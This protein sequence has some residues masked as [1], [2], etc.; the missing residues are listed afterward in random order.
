M[1]RG[2]GRRE[3]LTSPSRVILTPPLPRSRR[4]L[5]TEVERRPET[6]EGRERRG[7]TTEGRRTRGGRNPVHCIL[8]SRVAPST[9]VPDHETNPSDRLGPDGQHISR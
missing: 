2:P 7:T 8:V 6:G 5:S 1:S 9:G 4:R 3:R